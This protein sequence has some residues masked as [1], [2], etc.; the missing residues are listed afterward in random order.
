MVDLL[1]YFRIEAADLVERLHADA[2]LLERSPPRDDVRAI[3]ERLFRH[4]HTL[5]GSARIV[6]L[7]EAADHARA[8]EEILTAVRAREATF[9]ADEAASFF[10]LLDRVL[11]AIPS[12]EGGPP[13]AESR[14]VRSRA[15]TRAIPAPSAATPGPSRGGDTVALQRVPPDRP[16]ASPRMTDRAVSLGSLA[17]TRI[18]VR[19]IEHLLE[20]ASEAAVQA[21]SLRAV[22]R[23]MR[24]A[25]GVLGRLVADIDRAGTRPRTLD[26][27][28]LG[29]RWASRAAQIHASLVRDHQRFLGGLD[30]LDREIESIAKRVG[31]LRMV[32]ANSTFPPLERVVRDAARV[33]GRDVEFEAIG[34]E[35][36]VSSRI[37]AGVRDALVHVVRNAVAHGI[38]DPGTRETLGKP[39]RGVVRIEVE[40]KGRRVVFRCRDDGGGIDLERVRRAA[41]K[42][43]VVSEIEAA[44][45]PPEEVVELIFAPGLT[46]R[47]RPDDIS[48]RGVGLDVV[49]EEAC[50]FGADFRVESTRGV[51]TTIEISVPVAESALRVL[52]V[53]AGSLAVSLPLDEVRETLRVPSGQ[54]LASEEG[55]VLVVRGQALPYFPLRTLL[56]VVED[57]AG[58]KLST[59]SNPSTV[60][61]V[62]EPSRGR[63]VCAVVLQTPLGTIA[64][65]VERLRGSPR[66]HARSLPSLVGSPAAVSGVSLDAN[67]VPRLLVDV[68][69]L[70]ALALRAGPRGCDGPAGDAGS[71]DLPILVIDDSLTS[72]VLQAGILEAAGFQVE[73]AVN[74]LEALER[75]R[76][77]RFG[78]FIVDVEMPE[79]NGFEFIL[80]TKSD[81]ALRDIPAVIVTSLDGEAV[82]HR[83]L[84]VG[85]SHFIVKG[86]F[87]QRDL[88]GSVSRLLADG[89]RGGRV[90]PTS[91]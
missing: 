26:A 10:V 23:A 45:M 56:G 55:P 64:V 71:R 78:A 49:R 63:K 17:T 50:R 69:E 73:V 6:G 80:E 75:A 79:M 76:R 74:G 24:D 31:R 4:A 70:V 14:S 67:G 33:L 20:G 34:G 40:Q 32:Q 90:E 2:G 21:G 84:A 65:G 68:E 91:T 53:D 12:D 29:E 27:E 41:V 58:A 81:P 15:P 39:R 35:V 82:R 72:R 59:T 11:A 42:A 88:V 19:E 47:D 51:G 43:R 61:G 1:H 52:D 83:G 25:C 38:E 5:K 77:R 57:A 54:I 36:G 62:V 37:L 60:T 66:I 9:G 18:D 8:I 7:E 87:D 44:E 86:E 46:T 85:A 16:S 13:T 3:I 30:R 89:A 22:E 28:Q 48:G